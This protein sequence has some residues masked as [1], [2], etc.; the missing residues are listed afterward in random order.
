MAAEIYVLV[1]NLD[2]EAKHDEA[3]EE[4]FTGMM[5]VIPRVGEEIKIIGRDKH[6]I[7]H[8]ISWELDK[9]GSHNVWIV[10]EDAD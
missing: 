6:Y 5:T 9:Y 2:T 7:I 8:H 3:Y 4:L 10:T 1:E